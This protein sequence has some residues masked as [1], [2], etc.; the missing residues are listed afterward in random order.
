MG[1][2]A[3]N[4]RKG[5]KF[6]AVQSGGPGCALTQ[7]TGCPGLPL[8]PPHRHLRARWLWFEAD[9]PRACSSQVSFP[10]YG[11]GGRRHTTPSLGLSPQ[12]QDLPWPQLSSTWVTD[13]T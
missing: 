9:V 11:N 4:D 7:G 2:Q 12:T 3:R 1:G 5:W 13:Y 6:F 8:Q 10:P